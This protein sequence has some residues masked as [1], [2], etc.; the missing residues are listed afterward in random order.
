MH[1][2]WKTLDEKGRNMGKHKCPGD[3]G[4][5]HLWELR[6]LVEKVEAR[7]IDW[8]HSVKS[9]KGWSGEFIYNS[10]NNENPIFF[11]YPWYIHELL[12]C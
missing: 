10:L 6:L 5:C 3:S 7:K 9:L 12:N 11:S 2:K 1:F 4:Q 8:D